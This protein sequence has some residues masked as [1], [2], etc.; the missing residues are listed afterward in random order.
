M[1]PGQINEQRTPQRMR[2]K[3]SLTISWQISPISH[4]F[5]A[6]LRRGEQRT[7]SGFLMIISLHEATFQEMRA[8]CA[9]IDR[10]MFLQIL[11]LLLFFF[12]KSFLKYT[13]IFPTTVRT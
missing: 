13:S 8:I 2:K 9:G 6:L 3:F 11:I 12:K 5:T 1:N 10:M 4:K 7:I